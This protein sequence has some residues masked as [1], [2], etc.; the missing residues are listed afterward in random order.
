MNK[1]QTSKI[2]PD[3]SAEDWRRK[4]NEER[5]HEMNILVL[6]NIVCCPAGY[7]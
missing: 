5:S 4:L 7:K 2:D 3:K 1:P 6:I